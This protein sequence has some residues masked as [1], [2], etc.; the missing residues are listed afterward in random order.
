MSLEAARL[1]AEVRRHAEEVVRSRRRLLEAADAER[2]ALEQRLSE[3]VLTRLGRVDRLLA[4]RVYE[5]QRRELWA[6]TS[7]LLA[8]ARGLYPPAVDRADLRGALA[9]LVARF[10]LPVRVEIDGNPE[11]LPE[12]HRAAVWFTCSESLTNVGRH[13][14]ATSVDIRLRLD[15]ERLDLEIADDGVGGAALERGLRGLADRIEALGGTFV[16]SSPPGGPT[17]VRAV[18]VRA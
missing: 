10:E 11:L 3:R 18:L 9:E 4:R 6:A 16:L 14:G 12:S 8:L 15:D 17:V 2:R 1:D 7:E 5:P 13:A